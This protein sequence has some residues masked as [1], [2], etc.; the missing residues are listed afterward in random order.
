MSLGKEM[1]RGLALEA[2][3]NK[4][5]AGALGRTGRILAAHLATCRELAQQLAGATGEARRRLL[6]EYAESRRQAEQYRWYLYVQREAI[7][8]RRHDDVDATFPIPPIIKE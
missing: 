2:E 7:G 5:K 8:L 4:E 3:L 1:T 6:A